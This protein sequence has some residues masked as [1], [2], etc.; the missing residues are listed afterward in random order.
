MNLPMDKSVCAIMVTYNR[1][2]T[3]KIALS[4]IFKQTVQ[5]VSLIIVDNNS[6][7]GTKDYLASI[8]KS[9][10][11]E[12]IFLTTNVGAAGGYTYAMDYAL[13][14]YKDF[15][16]F[17]LIEDDTFYDQNTLHDL[18]YN[19]LNSPYDVISLKGFN[20]G[21]G[22][23]KSIITHDTIK[24]VSSV[25]LDGSLI[26]T[27]IIK[28]I[29]PPKK[30]YFMM[31]DD[32][33]FSLRLKKNGYK[34]ALIPTKSVN[35]LHLGGDGKFTRSTLWRGYYTARNHLL[36]LREYFSVI[37][38]L[39]YTHKQLKY[40]IAAALYAPDRFVRI[41]FRLLG[42]WHGIK[43]VDGMTL[44]PGTLKFVKKNGVPVKINDSIRTNNENVP[45]RG[46]KIDLKPAEKEYSSSPLITVITPTYNREIM[47]QTTIES[48]LNQTFRDW[49]LIIIDDGS[50]DNTE[51]VVSKYLSDPRVRY[52]KKANTGQ[53][54]SLNVAS[55]HA[56]G[57]FMTFLDSDD[58][59]YPNWLQT[60]AE[61]ISR[62]TGI[63]CNGAI[64]KLQDGTMINEEPK[65][66]IIFGKKVKLKFTCGSL[67]IKRSL[68][69]EIG[70]YDPEMKSNIQTDLGYRLLAYLKNTDYDAVAID[71]SLVQLNIH[72]GERIRSNWSKVKEGGLQLINKHFDIIKNS[73]PEEI[74]NMYMVVA[75]SNY[76]L[77]NRAEAVRFALKA[78]KHSPLQWKNYLKCFKYSIL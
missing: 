28:K 51:A 71:E 27:D 22:G 45:V 35:Y 16:Y 72:D 19:A 34:V 1:L 60:V 64:R 42:I 3:L 6:T 10:N 56:R 53:P 49:E 77:N 75:F 65:E 37:E 21:F 29:G 13:Q 24:P 63:V 67:F 15:E 66:T 23:S 5:P 18:I 40:L 31:C 52:Y 20:I 69:M 62:K 76:K 43:G 57:E 25:L 61:R 39:S 44:D 36:I 9:E 70:G 73:N 68:F 78:I 46:Q 17:W 54:D 48:V 74:S 38:I 30:E 47:V 41:K 11:I 50:T 26:K 33:E 8:D 55:R 32:Y 14:N 2:H 12:C 59:A 58:Q 4:Y 7:D